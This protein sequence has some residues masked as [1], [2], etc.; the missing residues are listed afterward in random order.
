[1]AAAPLQGVIFD[2][3]GTLIFPRKD[4]GA[5]FAEAFRAEGVVLDAAEATR[6]LAR[7]YRTGVDAVIAPDA[8]RA[9]RAFADLA[10]PAVLDA[11]L[12]RVD[13]G[14][15]DPG[16]WRV[17]PDAYAA[18]GA[19][20]FLGMKLVLLCDRAS[21]DRSFLGALGLTPFFEHTVF[22][23]DSGFFPK[24]DRRAFAAAL[25]ALN[26]PVGAV[27]VV[28]DSVATEIEPALAAGFRACLLGGAPLD[29][30]PGAYHAATLTVLV[31]RVRGEFVAPL[32]RKG[33]DRPVRNLVAD[34]RGLPRD[35]NRSSERGMTGTHGIADLLRRAR[36]GEAGAMRGMADLARGALGVEEAGVDTRGILLDAWPTL[37]VPRLRDKCFPIELDR[38]ALV[39]LCV[40]PVARNELKFVERALITA[41]R[42]LPGCTGVNKIVCRM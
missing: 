16:Q 6:A 31:E 13:A 3:E 26:L 20:R 17:A 41:V 42:R 4:V 40:S 18:L 28:G 2:L 33:F 19:L 37:I 32:E 24:P 27:L 29:A 21:S 11:V 1:M 15:R 9:R 23:G 35:L 10:T 14:M 8:D 39:I 36:D 38:D 22:C 7:I 34:L 12:A 30:V 5:R 25:R